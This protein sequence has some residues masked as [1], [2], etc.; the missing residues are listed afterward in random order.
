M[1]FLSGAER[2][3]T[4]H[5]AA[6]GERPLASVMSPEESLQGPRMQAGRG[7]ICVFWGPVSRE[8]LSRKG[9]SSGVPPAPPPEPPAAVSQVQPSPGRG[10]AEAPGAGHHQGVHCLQEPGPRGLATRRGRVA[11]QLPVS[12]Q[13]GTLAQRAP[14]SSPWAS[15]ERGARQGCRV[16][17]GSGPHSP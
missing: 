2:E 11:G 9:V 13:R 3:V 17:A 16:A 8:T 15:G 10:P 7:F 1:G 5:G 4:C 12:R 14:C 6:W